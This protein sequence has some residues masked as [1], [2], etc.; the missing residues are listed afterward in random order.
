[1]LIIPPQKKDEVNYIQGLYQILC[2]TH[3]LLIT[4]ANMLIIMCYTLCQALCF[5][6]H[7]FSNSHNIL[8][9]FYFHLIIPRPFLTN[10]IATNLF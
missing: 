7:S 5:N 4:I 10:F 1:M 3:T 6:T 2:G 8:E 9:K